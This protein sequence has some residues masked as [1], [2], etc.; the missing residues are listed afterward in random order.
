VHAVVRGFIAHPE[1]FWWQLAEEAQGLEEWD[2]MLLDASVKGEH[3]WSS[4]GEANTC[5]NAAARQLKIWRKEKAAARLPRF[6]LRV[7]VFATLTILFCLLAVV[8]LGVVAYEVP[9]LTPVISGVAICGS[10]P[11]ALNGTSPGETLP[12]ML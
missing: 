6:E 9:V 1:R 3:Q 8:F 4:Y 7:F 2:M 12:M 11:I 5:P 10:T